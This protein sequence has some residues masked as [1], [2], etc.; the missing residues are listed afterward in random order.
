MTSFGC[1]LRKGAFMHS[2]AE[3]IISIMLFLGLASQWLAWRMKLP[4]IVF[5]LSIGVMVGVTMNWLRIEPLDEEIL[6]PFVSLAVAVILF[7]GSLTLKFHDLPGLRRII[8]NLITFGVLINLIIISFATH[9]LFDSDWEVAFIFGALMVVTGPT[10]IMPLLRTVQPKNDVANILHWEGILIDPIGAILAVLIFEFIISGG[11]Q[12][13]ILTSVSVF[14]QMV[15]FGTGLGILGGIFFGQ[16][17]KRYWVPVYLHN[18]TALVIVCGI[19]S[20]SNLIRPESGLLAVTVMGVWISNRENVP[21]E[22]ILNFKESLS[23]ILI[24]LLFIVLASKIK[25]SE[26]I[27]L[28]VPALVIFLVI[29]F[30]ARPA[31]VFLCSIGSS[32][33]FKEKLFLSWIA[34]RGIV[35]AAISVIFAMSLD[36]LGLIGASDLVPLT[37]LIIFGT[38][39]LQSITAKAIAKWLN[40]AEAETNGFLIIGANKVA[41]AF[42]KALVDNHVQVVLSDQSFSEVSKSRLD[43]FKTYWGNVVSEHAERHLNFNGIGK[44]MALTPQNELNALAAKHYRMEFGP[45][46]IFVIKSQHTEERTALDKSTLTF[47]ARELFGENLTY[48]DIERLLNQHYI[49]KTTELTD[50]YTFEKYIS[51]EENKPIPLFA[52]DSSRN[53]YVFTKEI[54]FKPTTGWRIVSIIHG[55]PPDM[56]Q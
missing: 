6:F 15:L 52:I 22:D 12:G 3:F 5:L 36:G 45:A 23:V 48:S 54:D 7:E 21:L 40:V 39:M 4:A 17:L 35:A 28:G 13:G 19:F 42:A 43:G 49:L 51:R 8:R 25:I 18:F 32:L 9:W 41:R 34:P 26:F 1:A 29:Q 53:I 50:E 10:V 56:M 47:G 55:A 46:N 2:N 31:C 38:V 14:G 30:I 24:S 16:I 11:V 27:D 37:F 44:L 20:L 33:S